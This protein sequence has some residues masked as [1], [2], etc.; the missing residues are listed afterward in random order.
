MVTKELD[1]EGCDL[2]ALL[3]YPAQLIWKS[4]KQGDLPDLR[5]AHLAL[6][7][8]CRLSHSNDIS[9][10]WQHGTSVALKY[11]SLLQ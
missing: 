10:L 5:H 4:D 2:K 6:Y 11:A 7:R 9:C 8:V 3:V 1:V